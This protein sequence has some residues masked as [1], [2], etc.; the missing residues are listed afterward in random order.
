[1]STVLQESRV[2]LPVHDALMLCNGCGRLSRD[3]EA[4][5]WRC[6]EDR[7]AAISH[8]GQ[9]YSFTSVC[10]D[11]EPFVLALVELSCG[12]LVT[13]RIIDAGQELKIGSPVEFHPEISQASQSGGL[14]FRPLATG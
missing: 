12:R 4:S 14:F 13:A 2:S 10:T 8:I 11:G 9:V 6:G 1:M 7:P 5:C 3:H